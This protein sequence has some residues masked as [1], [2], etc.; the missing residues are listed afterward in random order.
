VPTFLMG[1]TLPAAARGVEAGD[2]ARRSTALLYGVNTL[3]AVAGCALATFY[4]LEVIGTRGTLWLACAVNLAIAA[5]ARRVGQ[6]GPA[7][8]PS[9]AEASPTADT[10]D[11]TNPAPAWFS[12]AAACIVGFAFF[13]M[14]MV[15]YRMLG[16]ILGG[17]VFTFGLILAVALLGIGLGGAC[18]AVFGSG[19]AATLHGFATTCLLEAVLMAVPYALGDRVAVLTLL[20][21]SLGLFGFSGL[22][23]G[24]SAITLLV[25]FPAAF[26]AGVQ[27][28]LLIGL[29]GHGRDHVGKQIGLAYA[30][31]TLGAIAGSLGGGFGLLPMLTAPGCWRA[32]L[33]ILALLGVAAIALSTAKSRR[34][35]SRWGRYA[36]AIAACAALV[37]MLRATG[38]TAV[39][40]HSPIGVGRVDAEVTSSE[41]ALRAWANDERRALKWEAEG[42]ESSVA[43]SNAQ[44]WAFIVNG[45]IDGSA[46]G[47]AATQVMGGLVGGILHPNPKKALVIGLG[48]GSTAGWL[49]S[50]PSIDRVDV[51]EF[52]P[53]IRA[54]A[55]ACVSVNRNVMENPKVHVTIGDAREVLLTTPERYDIV[56]S[57]PSNP[58][59]AGI[60]SLFTREYY[61][62]VRSRLRD[63]GLFLQWVQAYN[64]DAQ[65]VRTIYAT[66]GSEFGSIETWELA[67]ND[68]LLVASR[69]PISYDAEGLRKRIAEEPYRS[70]LSSAWRAVDIEGFFAHYVARDSMAQ[71]IGKAEGNRLNTDDRTLVEFGF[72][73]MAA[74]NDALGGKEIRGLAF[75]RGEHRPGRFLGALDWDRV[76]EQ[77]YGFLASED[78]TPVPPDHFDPARKAR[79]LAL[80]RFVD[81]EPAKTSA[82]WLSQKQEPATPTELAALAEGLAS[83]GD[84]RA[85]PYIDKLRVHQPTEAEGIEARLL[86][87]RGR[88][89]EAARAIERMFARHRQDVWSWAI[90]TRHAF[91][92]IDE[93]VAAEPALATRMYDA[94]RHPLPVYLH[95]ES[96]TSAMLRLAMHGKVDESCEATLALFEPHVPWRKDVLEWRSGCYAKLGGER[97]AFA[98]RDVAEFASHEPAAFGA[99]LP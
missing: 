85:R 3:G 10:E 21:R 72:A 4:L 83:A 65:A 61:D 99:G 62:A 54:V 13:L 68:L 88:H 32:T 80:A 71:A 44:G 94:L 16:P 26:V 91:T 57:E 38:P 89:E 20:V 82:H 29:L 17:T 56:F 39:W 58:Y 55:A 31:N 18:Y 45:K 92:T 95:E 33:G 5:I 8:H 12:L 74:D 30:F 11:L 69:H 84:E 24:W 40:R 77:W 15:W 34:E 67:A 22:L 64:V 37:A 46:R 59:R 66:L 6:R 35:G 52:E 50:V 97:A 27:F 1:G 53:V 48:T 49:A 78:E 2:G 28:P 19:R 86:E 23:C 7:A 70:A 36:G 14:E 98:A 93:I 73:R 51:V 87:R 41:T 81:G 90:V 25:V 76:D 47:D 63:D 43:L 42:V 79:V 9:R 60:A 75:E 96:R